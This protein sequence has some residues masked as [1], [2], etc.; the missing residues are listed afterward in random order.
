MQVF[1][2]LSTSGII[3]LLNFGSHL[4]QL[5]DSE[6]KAFISSCCFDITTRILHSEILNSYITLYHIVNGIYYTIVPH[7][8][9][10]SVT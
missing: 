5:R 10:Y 3:L 2:D 4:E 8:L 7:I 1:F 9:G 6:V